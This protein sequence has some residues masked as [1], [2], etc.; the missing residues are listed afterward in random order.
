MIALSA[1]FLAMLTGILSAMHACAEN[2]LAK[3]QVLEKAQ[4]DAY[5][6]S[7]GPACCQTQL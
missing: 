4:N 1:A 6:V 7:S 3:N 5:E 2:T